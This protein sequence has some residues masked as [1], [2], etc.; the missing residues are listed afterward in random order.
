MRKEQP[1]G[2]DL[3]TCSIR[4]TAALREIQ[5]HCLPVNPSLNSLPFVKFGTPKF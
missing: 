5:H 1:S 2:S 3:T 4:V